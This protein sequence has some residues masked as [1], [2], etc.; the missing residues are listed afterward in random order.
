MT[1]PLHQR[2][3]IRHNVKRILLGQTAAGPRVFADQ[4]E[5]NRLNTLP[6]IGIYSLAET[7]T[8]DSVLTAPRQL[9]H[10]LTLVIEAWVDSPPANPDDQE[11]AMTADKLDRICYE[12]E[13]AMH[14]D[15]FLPDLQGR[16]TCGQSIKAGTEIQFDYD[17]D[18]RLGLAAITYTV[19][20]R[21]SAPLID[22]GQFDDFDRLGTT[23]DLRGE[24]DPDDQ[25]HDLI[26][27]GVPDES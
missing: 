5:K 10:L 14:A 1:A 13:K 3:L 8:D 19:T 22:D 11:G 24:Q 6:V 17:G 7:V 21:T 16:P 23:R 12:I 18:R 9:T 27:L 2:E 20:Y 26:E 4:I 25:A 15:P